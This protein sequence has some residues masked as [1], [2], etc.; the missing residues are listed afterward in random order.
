MRLCDWVN[1]SW[2]CHARAA[3]LWQATRAVAVSVAFGLLHWLSIIVSSCRAKL[4]QS[5]AQAESV[6]WQRLVQLLLVPPAPPPV[7]LTDSNAKR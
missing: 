7:H 5:N 2:S 1:V 6:L 4:S 3:A